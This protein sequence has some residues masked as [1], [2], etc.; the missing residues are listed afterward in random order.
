MNI[1]ASYVFDLLEKHWDLFSEDLTRLIKKI[2]DENQLTDKVTDILVKSSS[3]TLFSIV[4]TLDYDLA[5]EHEEIGTAIK[6]TI[7]TNY[8]YKDP[9]QLIALTDYYQANR[10]T[11]PDFESFLVNYL[12]QAL[13]SL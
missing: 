9:D 6:N 12:P 4:C 3:A 7:T 13:K 8:L 1:T 5:K 11:Y 10:D 2:Y